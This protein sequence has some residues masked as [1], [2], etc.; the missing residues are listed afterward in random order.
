MYNG[1]KEEV[2]QK[3]SEAEEQ[4]KSVFETIWDSGFDQTTINYFE[5]L[6]P[7]IQNVVSKW[8]LSTNIEVTPEFAG[9]SSYEDFL[10]WFN[11]DPELDKKLGLEDLRTRINE[12]LV[13]SGAGVS[14][15]ADILVS[16]GFLRSEA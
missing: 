15:L 6:Y 13:G 14:D 4:I 5:S 9:F 12:M 16:N 3:V 10:T 8:K 11:S 2:Q 7:D 1:S